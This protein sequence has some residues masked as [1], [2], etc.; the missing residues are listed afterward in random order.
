MDLKTKMEQGY[1]YH[2]FD[3]ENEAYAIQLSK[4]RRQCK[5]LLQVF[6]ATPV[7]N[8]EARTTLLSQIT[9]IDEYGFVEGPIYFAYGKNT[10]IGKHFYANFNLS[11]VDDGKVTIHD[12]VLLAPNVTI[13]TTGHPIDPTLRKTGVQYSLPVTI[14]SNVWI[15]AGVIILPGVT[16]GENSVIGAGSIVT[17]DIEANCVAFG[18]PCR[19]VRDISEYDK[20][21]YA[22]NRE[23][24]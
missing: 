11:I 18:T 20:K 2:E 16:I 1:L 21:Y 6:N 9:N 22:K 8:Q 10:Y 23:I 5:D 24:E 19:K 14:E 3:Q 4:Q 13:T 15:G 12:H 17:H 7:S